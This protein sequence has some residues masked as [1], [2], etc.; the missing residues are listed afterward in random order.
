VIFEITGLNRP[1]PQITS[2]KKNGGGDSKKT[3]SE[4]RKSNLDA[5]HEILVDNDDFMAW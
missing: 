2:K 4:F 5:S 3:I 1:K